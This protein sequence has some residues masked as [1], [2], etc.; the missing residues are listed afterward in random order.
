MFNEIVLEHFRNPR[1]AGD[2]EGAASAQVTNP[3]CGDVLRLSAQMEDGR[4]RAARFKA[5]GCVA[6]IACGSALTELLVGKSLAEAR[7]ITSQIISDAL[8]GLPEATIH[9][10][11]LCA[12]AIAALL[13]KLSAGGR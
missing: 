1:N 2:L 6:A 10:A 9:A 13:P 12:D 3:V 7:L 11:H 8:G 4:I 5:Q